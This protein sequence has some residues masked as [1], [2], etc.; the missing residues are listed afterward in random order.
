MGV[1]KVIR[2]GGIRLADKNLL[3]EVTITRDVQARLASL[4]LPRLRALSPKVLASLFWPEHGRQIIP[5][6]L[7]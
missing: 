2:F 3:T 5:G 4:L 7:H 1:A 6:S